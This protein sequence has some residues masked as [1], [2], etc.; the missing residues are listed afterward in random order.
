MAGATAGG[1]DLDLE[2]GQ[3]RVDFDLLGDEPVPAEAAQGVDLDIG[4]AVGDLDATAESQSGIT[5][6]NVALLEN[7]FTRCTTGTTRQMTL[8][9]C[10][11]AAPL[12]QRRWKARRWSSRS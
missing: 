6:R 1:V 5:D 4:S 2:G 3:S 10:A 9:K 11:R 8:A 12:A 7:S